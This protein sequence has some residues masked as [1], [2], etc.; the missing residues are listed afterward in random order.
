MPIEVNQAPQGFMQWVRL[1]ELLHA[2]FAYQNGRI[3]PP[4]MG[5]QL[6]RS[7]HRLTQIQI[8]RGFLN[9]SDFGHAI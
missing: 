7:V 5:N 4:S 2:A 8:D 6:D 9:Y 1:L 3:D